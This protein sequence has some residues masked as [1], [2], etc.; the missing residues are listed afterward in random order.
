MINLDFVE[1]QAEKNAAFHLSCAEALAK[2][3]NVL[4]T[5]LLAG[6]GASFWYTVKLLVAGTTPWL[7]CGVSSI[8]VYLFFLS[9][10]LTW[11]CLWAR[12]MYPPANEP[13]NLTNEELE[14]DEIRR[15]DLR[16]RQACI[17]LNRERN[18][19][20][21]LWLNRCRIAIAAT[22]LIFAAVGVLVVAH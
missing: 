14:L 3:A 10:L 17:D 9:G 16:N 1:V 20:V 19:S 5:I 18:D 12:E 6:G 15:L 7:L 21:G 13:Q 11:K 8:A 2:E 22:P 4:L